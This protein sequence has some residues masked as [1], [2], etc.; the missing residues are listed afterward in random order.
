MILPSEKIIAT[1]QIQYLDAENLI[2]GIRNT[3]H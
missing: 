1:T 3:G 2:K